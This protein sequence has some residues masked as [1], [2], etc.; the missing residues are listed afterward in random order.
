MI[1]ADIL[2]KKI[3]LQKYGL[4]EAIKLYIRDF[5][6]VFEF[7]KQ[8]IYLIQQL[9]FDNLLVFGKIR[10]A[11]SSNI[12]ERFV[13]FYR[14]LRLWGTCKTIR[15]LSL[16]WHDCCNKGLCESVRKTYN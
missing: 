3:N 9:I 10:L 2:L 15:L 4:V 1:L 16:R 5:E 8:N 11:L 13:L 12:F 7:F 6:I 14:I